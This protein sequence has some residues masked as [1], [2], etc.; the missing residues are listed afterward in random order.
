AE[1]ERRA[2]AA[3]K[4]VGFDP[5]HEEGVRALMKALAD[6]GDHVQ[7]LREYERCRAEL[8]KTYD[9]PPS[10][11]TTA[12]R[13][14]IRLVSSRNN[15]GVQR[16]RKADVVPLDG[17]SPAAPVLGPPSIAVLPFVNLSGDPRH[18]LSAAAL[19]EDLIGVLSRV[20]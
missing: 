17:N 8:R 7:A 10:R 19:A 3:R 11:E 14:A 18:N 4:L 6:L 20:P 1:A 9:V 5:T 2:A 12:L 16:S 13:E 15:I